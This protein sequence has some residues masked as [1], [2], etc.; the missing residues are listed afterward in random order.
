MSLERLAAR[1]L[2][3]LRGERDEAAAEL[4][5]R[6]PERD[7]RAGRGL[8]E[9]QAE[10]PAREARRSGR[11]SA[12][13]ARSRIA[14]ASAGTRSAILQEIAAGERD[15]ERR[16]HSQRSFAAATAA[17]TSPSRGAS[18]ARRLERAGA[19]RAR[20][21][22]RGRRG[23][24]RRRATSASA[25]SVARSSGSAQACREPLAVEL[26]AAHEDGERRR[27]RRRRR[28]ARRTRAACPPAGRGCR[29]AA[30]P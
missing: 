6:D 4:D 27:A 25:A 21:P 22:A 12:R 15:G 19:H 23:T 17:P 10:R 30:G 13:S 28:R 3:L 20:R 24:G 5:D 29:R 1:E 11:A 26:E 18:V 7:P 8:A 16:F 14:S 9:D 2:H